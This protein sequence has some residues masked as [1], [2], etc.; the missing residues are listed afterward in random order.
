MP[1]G[2]SQS[3]GVV[4][5]AV[6]DI[7]DQV[8]T[9]KDALEFRMSIRIGVKSPLLTWLVEHA[10]W[11]YNNCREY[12]DKKTGTERLQSGRSIKPVA[13]LGESI[14]YKPLSSKGDA[15]DKLEA[16]FEEGIWLGVE[17]R[18]GEIRMGTSSGVAKSRTI[19]RRIEAEGWNAKAAQEIT[20]TPWNPAPGIQAKTGSSVVDVPDAVHAEP[21]L[22]GTT[23][24]RLDTV[25]W[26]KQR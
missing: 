23:E 16:R 14:L 7:E 4:E 8:R 3:N 6:R 5:K 19:R 26:Q 21:P 13:E 1:V 24:S 20:G 25:V 15:V 22:K 12:K 18:T 2:E 11:L 10:A 17:S 9:L